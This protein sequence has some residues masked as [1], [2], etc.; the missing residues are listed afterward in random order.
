MADEYK[1]PRLGI[2]YPEDDDWQAD[3]VTVPFAGDPIDVCLAGGTDDGPSAEALLA[4]EWC[5]QNWG[6]V[7]TLIQD[8]AFEFYLPYA[9]AVSSVPKFE[10]ADALWGTEE[11]ISLR[12]FS[13]NDFTV[14]LCFSWQEEADPHLVTFYVEEGACKS[15]SVDG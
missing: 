10:T 4:Y 5:E 1:H 8:Q 9:D 7:L 2:L 13:K 14:T 15:H 6:G 3:E 12:V 11:V